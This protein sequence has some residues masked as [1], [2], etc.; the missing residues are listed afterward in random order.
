VSSSSKSTQLGLA[1]KAYAAIREQIL[2]GDLRL[3]AVLSRRKLARQLGTSLFPISE[4][5]QRLESEGLVESKPQVGTRVLVPSEK[6]IRERFII[7]EA[8]ECQSARLVAERATFRQR[9]ELKRMAESVD[10][11]FNRQRA[12][13]SDAKFAFAVQSYHMQI[14]MKIAEYS[15]CA[16]LMDMIDKNNLLVLNWIFDLV[17]PEI[18]RPARLHRDLLEVVTGSSPD[19][20]EAAMRQHVRIG[21]ERTIQAIASFNAS[22]DGRWR[23]LDHPRNGQSNVR[24]PRAYG[25]LKS[26]DAY[27]GRKEV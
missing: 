8:L 14:H 26:R 15:D 23:I 17:V 1:T 7:R 13:D 21:I 27:R 4:A 24:A 18:S 20:A 22:S 11:L 5:I 9:A 10:A 16:A 3:G 25:L 19:A 6:D 2:R 12:G